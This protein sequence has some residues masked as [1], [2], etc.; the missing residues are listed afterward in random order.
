ME[1]MTENIVY[2]FE[3]VYIS[4]RDHEGRIYTD[5]EV[6]KLP[7]IADDHIY[8][9]EWKIRKA[10]SQR[11][12]HYLQKKNK[13]LRILEVGCGNGWLSHCLSTVENSIVKGI[14]INQV[15]L[16][17]AS[18][19][20]T[21]QKNLSFHYDD[22]T[23][24]ALKGEYFDV[25]VFAASIQYFQSFR[26]MINHALELLHPKGEIH[27]LD[28]HFYSAKEVDQAK[29]RSQEYF[30]Q[31]DCS[32]MSRFYFHHSKEDLAAF[33]YEILYNAESFFN[34]LIPNKNP[35]NWVCIKNKK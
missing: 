17:Q 20:F 10:S 32:P 16:S 34:K 22:I 21:N 13:S 27:I 2:N 5:D 14:D 30:Q 3:E 8:K 25:I 31:M 9:Q 24:G 1:T 19:V 26:S 11:L 18:R 15:E 33:D 12:I 6:A 35:F 29:H 28:T 4:L 23:E 7:N